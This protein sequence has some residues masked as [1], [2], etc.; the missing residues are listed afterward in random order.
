MLVVLSAMLVAWLVA[1][2]PSFSPLLSLGALLVAAAVVLGRHRSIPPALAA[3]FG[4][5]YVGVP[6]GLLANL[7]STAG[8]KMTMLLLAVVIVSDSLQYYTGRLF[9]RRPLAPR[10]SPKKTVEGAVGGVVAAT[11]FMMAAGPALLPATSPA[12]LAGVGPVLALL[13]IS[14]DL[15]ESQLKRIAGLKDS[16]HLIP[17]HGGVLD[18]V[19]ALLFVTPAFFLAYRGAA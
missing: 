3:P 18:R 4:V 14:G 17:G 12:M 15:F 1:D 8:W 9:G 13:G 10:V 5:L 16:S 11:L 2:V 6:F 7:R 19:D